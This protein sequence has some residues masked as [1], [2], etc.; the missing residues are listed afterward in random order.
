M[1]PR[2]IAQYSRSARPLWPGRVAGLE[3]L[4][5]VG[6]H[7]MPWN[8]R[9]ASGTAREVDFIVAAGQLQTDSPTLIM[10]CGEGRHCLEL[11]R[12]GL[13][14]VTGLDLS[15]ALTRLAAA[16]AQSERLDIVFKQGDARHP[17]LPPASFD[18]VAI[19]GDAFGLFSG[20]EDPERV[21]AAARELL[22]PSGRLVLEFSD[23]ASVSRCIARRGWDW[24]DEHHF[25][26]REHSP[27]DDRKRL[28]SRET[29]VGHAS[30]VVAKRLYAERLYSRDAIGKL[31]R[32]AG[33]RNIRHHGS[34]EVLSARGQE[35]SVAMPRL[36]LSADAPELR[37]RTP[38]RRTRRIDVTVVMGD[39]RQ[40]D[41][42]KRGGKFNPEDLEA[43]GCLKEALSELTGYTFHYLDNHATLYQDLSELSTDL[44]F[45]L[46]DEG[47]NNDPFKELHVPALLE[48]LGMPY[49]GAGPSAL[50]VCYDKNLVRTVAVTLDVPVPL[51]AH[52]R[53]G[54]HGAILPSPFPV[55]LKPNYGDGSEGITKDAV[56][57]SEKALIK[58]L[59]RLQRA[60]PRRSI[61]VQEYLPGREY[62]VG[63]IGNPEQELRALPILEVDYSQ[64]D[65]KLPKIL[66]YESK[67]LPGSAYWTQ[68]R[69]RQAQLSEPVQDQLVDRAM[70]LF[71]RLG[72]RDS[73]RFDF[74]ADA[75]GE[76]KLL[77]AN[78][79]PGW[80]WDGKLNMM[81]GFSGL[82]YSQL[83]AQILS[84]AVKRLAIAKTSP[85]MAPRVGAAVSQS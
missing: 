64:L 9:C 81:A 83:L 27:A 50:A 79:N 7:G 23:S 36:R 21:L 54:D 66:G 26:C 70:R 56:A 80:C 33:F 18:C 15:R 74:R 69:Y 29:I 51:E 24:I 16:Q 22:R 10:C 52:V 44:V 1:A 11:A 77:D 8:A 71:E 2:N 62:S 13:R 85:V 41:A 38:K 61:L 31:L 53:P 57:G 40:P 72:C 14:N 19:M 60:F 20:R 58:G 45:N 47:F 76:T 59:E 17:P 30:G 65:P 25:V 75:S 5:A 43:I 3:V 68:V 42:V 84:V 55:L 48:M 78:P 28:I 49:T 35:H 6:R 39:P 63:L 46:C 37:A 32:K 34:A 4:L 73:A 82:S 12:R 67:W